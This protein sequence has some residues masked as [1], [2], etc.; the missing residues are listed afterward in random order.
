MRTNATNTVDKT[1]SS[2]VSLPRR[3]RWRG[4]GGLRLLSRSGFQGSSGMLRMSRR[5]TGIRWFTGW[6]WVVER[7]AALARIV[8]AAS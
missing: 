4:G 3:K 2:G 6:Q 5:L 7:M 1:G 8:S